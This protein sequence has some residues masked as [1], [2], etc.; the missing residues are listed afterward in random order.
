MKKKPSGLSR[1]DFERVPASMNVAQLDIDLL[2]FGYHLVLQVPADASAELSDDNVAVAE[3]VHVEID[4]RARL[5]SSGFPISLKSGAME[6]EVF[7]GREAKLTSR[8]M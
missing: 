1:F 4:V 2:R 5:W 8:E 7:E 6:T 3:K